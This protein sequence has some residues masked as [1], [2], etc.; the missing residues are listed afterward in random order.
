MKAAELPDEGMI[1]GI[2]FEHFLVV[3]HWSA[4]SGICPSRNTG[5]GEQTTAP[6]NTAVWRKR[7][8]RP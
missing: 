2:V 8:P 6:K 7:I 4:F 5:D 3:L 1:G